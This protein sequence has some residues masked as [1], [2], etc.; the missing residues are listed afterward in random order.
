[1]KSSLFALSLLAGAVSQAHAISPQ[2]VLDYEFVLSASDLDPFGLDGSKWTFNFA[3][4]QSTYSDTSVYGVSYTSLVWDSVSVT[5]A[6]SSGAYNGTYDLFDAAGTNYALFAN[7]ETQPLIYPAV[8]TTNTDGP[9]TTA[10]TDGGTFMFTH[11]A[12]AGLISESPQTGD[13]VVQSDFEDPSWTDL[14]GNSFTFVDS[15]SNTADYVYTV[16]PEPST[17]A[18]LGGLAALGLIALRRR[19]QA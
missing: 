10:Y 4:T 3:S 9:P 17:Y 14:I 1:M 6:G 7:M 2:V 18:A 13:S 8:D 11:Y 16:V 19:K 15:N 12:V 5:I